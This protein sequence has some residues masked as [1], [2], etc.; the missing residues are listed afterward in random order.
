MNTEQFIV[1]AAARGWS[2]QMVKETLGINQYSFKSI[3]ELMPP[4]KW[5]THSLK[6]KDDWNARKGYCT[7]AQRATLAKA[8][9]AVKKKHSIVVGGY[10]G[11]MTDQIEHWADLVTVSHAQINRRL[12]KG[13][14]VYDALFLGKQQS[15]VVYKHGHFARTK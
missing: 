8:K 1:D 7:D 3:L 5:P 10:A 12:V 11:T 4:I 14:S 15:A 2:R 9:V 6:H 13:W